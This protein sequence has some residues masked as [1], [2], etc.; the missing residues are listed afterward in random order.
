MGEEE[1]RF[2]AEAAPDWGFVGTRQSLRYEKEGRKS[3]RERE[4]EKTGELGLR[5]ER[6]QSRLPIPGTQG[7]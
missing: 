6:V 4:R 2:R 1:S 3:R 5:S 7:R